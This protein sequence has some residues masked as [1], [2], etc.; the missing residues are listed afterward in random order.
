MEH[1]PSVQYGE[2]FA[3]SLCYLTLCLL[4]TVLVFGVLVFPNAH[5]RAWLLAPQVALLFKLAPFVYLLS[6]ET[7][8]LWACR[9]TKLES[10]LLRNVCAEFNGNLFEFE[11]QIVVEV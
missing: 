10:R 7:H 2:I 3:W 11:A 6:N 9:W 4:F 5:S 8:I 1:A